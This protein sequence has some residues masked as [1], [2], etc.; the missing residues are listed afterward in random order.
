MQAKLNPYLSFR[1]NAR[2]AMEFY[3]T[4]FGGEL[5][6]HTFDEYGASQDPTEDT[7]IMH[8]MLTVDNDTLF[9]GADTPARMEYADKSNV[10]LSLSGDNESELR[11]YFEKLS[12]GGTITMPLEVAP[13]S[14]A[15]GMCKDKFGISWMVNITKQ[16]Q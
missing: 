4:V 2:E 9:M 5:E 13:W 12:A 3:Q 7:K 15:F 8:S 10:S 1:D 6:F 14:D 11:E 16:I